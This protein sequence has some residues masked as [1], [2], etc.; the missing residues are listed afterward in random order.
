M[1][2]LFVN[3]CV[4]LVAGSSGWMWINALVILEC[5]LPSLLTPPP[6]PVAPL[7][8]FASNS[9]PLLTDSLQVVAVIHSSVQAAPK[10]SA[11]PRTPRRSHGQRPERTAVHYIRYVR[12]RRFLRL[13]RNRGTEPENHFSNNQLVS[14]YPWYPSSR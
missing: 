10:G 2:W 8:N 1:I 13:F 5:R 11:G 4:I 12:Q 3:G 6:T 14:L 9:R 7:A